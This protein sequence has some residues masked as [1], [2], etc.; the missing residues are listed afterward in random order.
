MNTTLDWQA[1]IDAELQ[2]GKSLVYRTLPD[3][4]KNGLYDT[5]NWYYA[6]RAAV[7]VYMDPRNSLTENAIFQFEQLTY[8]EQYHTRSFSG[9]SAGRT[10]GR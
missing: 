3:W 6:S 8:N 10:G 5:G 2:G 1:T 9:K 7:E 4:A